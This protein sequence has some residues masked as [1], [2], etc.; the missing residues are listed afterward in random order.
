[1]GAFAIMSEYDSYD[2]EYDVS[3]LGQMSELNFSLPKSRPIESLSSLVDRI[4]KKQSYPKED[5]RRLWLKKSN[6]RD[7]AMKQL[8]DINNKLEFWLS[9]RKFVAGIIEEC[10]S[11]LE[12]LDVAMMS[13]ITTRK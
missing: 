8:R 3:D 10:E 7:K 12:K 9:K 2:L 6:E 4:E 13:D 5:M 11:S 1:M